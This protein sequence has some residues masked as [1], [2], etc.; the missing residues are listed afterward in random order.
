MIACLCIMRT[1]CV[2]HHCQSQEALFFLIKYKNY[3]VLIDPGPISRLILPL[4]L[5]VHKKILIP[6]QIIHFILKQKLVFSFNRFRERTR[7]TAQV[8][9]SYGWTKH[10]GC[11]FT[12][13]IQAKLTNDCCFLWYFSNHRLFIL[14]IQIRK[15]TRTYIIT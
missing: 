13:F 10:Q 7:G 3:I 6:F 11:L 1:C 4:A 2:L 15:S 12:V 8:C 14:L 5:P 9:A